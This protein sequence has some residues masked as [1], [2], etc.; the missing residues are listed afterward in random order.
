MAIKKVTDAF[1]DETDAKRTLREIKLL[2]FLNHENVS[3]APAFVC[4]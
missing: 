1:S 2:G 4:G 3:L